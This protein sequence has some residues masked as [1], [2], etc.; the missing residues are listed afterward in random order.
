MILFCNNRVMTIGKKATE[1]VLAYIGAL[2]RGEY[3]KAA[4]YLSGKI[5]IVGPAGE[6]FSKPEEFVGMLQK[7]HGKYELKKTFTD[8]DDVCVLYDL[9][10]Q[11]AKVFMSSWYHVTDGKITFI[12]TVFDPRAFI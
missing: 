2:D 6:S 3:D 12:Q 7:Y 1:V 11:G 9:I 5:R 8:S 10:T 4:G